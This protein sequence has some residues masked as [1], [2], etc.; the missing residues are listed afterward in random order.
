MYCGPRPVGVYRR[1][2]TSGQDLLLFPIAWCF[3]PLQS[4]HLIFESGASSRCMRRF[5]SSYLQISE[6]NMAFSCHDFYLEAT[7]TQG[8]VIPAGRHVLRPLLFS[9]PKKWHSEV[10]GQRPMRS[11]RRATGLSPTHR[12]SRQWG[13]LGIS[14]GTGVILYDSI[15]VWEGSQNDLGGRGCPS[16]RLQQSIPC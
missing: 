5:I 16:F 3:L 13:D 7:G 8:S 1:P 14:R 2:W 15:R 10:L 4:G 9:H 11:V 12:V 6:K